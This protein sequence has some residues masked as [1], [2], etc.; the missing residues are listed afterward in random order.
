MS[1]KIFR[2]GILIVTTYFSMPNRVVAKD[3]DA[4]PQVVLSVCKAALH[5]ACA[6]EYGASWGF[7]RNFPC[8]YASIGTN[9]Y[10]CSGKCQSENGDS[11]EITT[12]AKRS[13]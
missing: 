8:G 13:R 2:I 3:S 7:S 4:S 6:Q 10:V 5:K 1:K 9:E 11:Q 12:T